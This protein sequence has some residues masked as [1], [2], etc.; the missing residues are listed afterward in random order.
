[1]FAKVVV[2][3]TELY[4][5]N[6]ERL[7]QINS[8]SAT[9]IDL[10]F[11]DASAPTTNGVIVITLTITT[12]KREDVITCIHEQISKTATGGKLAWEIWDAVKA[13]KCCQDITNATVAKKYK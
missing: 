9:S 3:A 5:I 4:M 7:L 8:L 11:N 13:T 12:G 6:V 10:I 2:S 1:M